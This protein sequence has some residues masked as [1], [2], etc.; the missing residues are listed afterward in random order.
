MNVRYTP[1]T[2]FSQEQ[3]LVR[4]LPP[5]YFLRNLQLAC[6]QN[7]RT[8]GLS[9]ACHVEATR[10]FRYTRVQ[11]QNQRS[12]EA[13]SCLDWSGGHTVPFHVADDQIQVHQLGPIHAASE[14][15]A[16]DILKIQAK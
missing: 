3:Y 2:I 14:Q 5:V 8:F 9:P 13:L 6:A 1:Q 4:R 16:A 12:I 15:T 10:P 11:L 7:T